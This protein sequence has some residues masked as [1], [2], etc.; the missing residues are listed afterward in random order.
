M[1]D[2]DTENGKKKRTGNKSPIS[3]PAEPRPK[4]KSTIQS[5]LARFQFKSKDTVERD[6]KVEANRE[7]SSR[8][9][10]SSPNPQKPCPK[11]KLY[12][13]ELDSEFHKDDREDIDNEDV[14]D[15]TDKTDSLLVELIHKRKLLTGRLVSSTESLDILTDQDQDKENLDQDQDQDKED[16][17][18]DQDKENI[19]RDE[20][21]ENL[22]RDEGKENLD[23]HK[24]EENLDNKKEPTLADIMNG[25]VIHQYFIYFCSYA[26]IIYLPQNCSTSEESGCY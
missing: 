1:E 17:D 13:D 16:L 21:K 22:D 2:M 10:T 20:D 9:K 6:D 7:I 18:Q 11:E 12:E 3:K 25:K 4:P 14:N 15:E 5:R 23:Q 24:D 26:N 8:K 19:D